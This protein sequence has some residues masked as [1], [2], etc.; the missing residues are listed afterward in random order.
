MR[1]PSR[2]LGTEEPS[3]SS[4]GGRSSAS[5]EFALLPHRFA[6]RTLGLRL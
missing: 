2:C 3:Y 5:E 6:S 1:C 4:A